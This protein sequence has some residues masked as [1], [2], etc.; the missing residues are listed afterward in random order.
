MIAYMLGAKEG[1]LDFI[2]SIAGPVIKG[3][4]TSGYQN[5]ILVLTQGIPEVESEQFGLA[6]ERAFE[7]KLQYG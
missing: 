4:K 3:T 5:K 6:V 1:N 7:Y 2:V